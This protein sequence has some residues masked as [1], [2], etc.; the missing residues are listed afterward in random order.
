MAA[1][2]DLERALAALE[3][4][5]IAVVEPVFG[6]FDLP[7]VGNLLAEHAVGV[8]YAVAMRGYA[9]R[10]HRLHEAGGETSETAIAKRGIRLETG[11]DV[12]FHAERLQ[13]GP[14]V[15]Q[16]TQIG[17]SVP[18]QSSD[19]ELKRQ[20]INALFLAGRR[21]PWWILSTGR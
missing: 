11:D 5:R 7:A 4:P 18:H 20:V 21:L 16:K 9:D 1:E 14:H 8:A 17:E 2:T 12:Q 13:S 15:L 3:F 6:K 19:E 10:C